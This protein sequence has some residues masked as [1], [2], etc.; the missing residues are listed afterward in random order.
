MPEVSVWIGRERSVR[1][2]NLF[3]RTLP[4]WLANGHGI[5]LPAALKVPGPDRRPPGES[6]PEPGGRRLER[7]AGLAVAAGQLQCL[8]R[9]PAA[10]LEEYRY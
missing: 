7:Q 10:E 5:E 1:V 4:E 3:F 2:G 9:R 8:V 6:T